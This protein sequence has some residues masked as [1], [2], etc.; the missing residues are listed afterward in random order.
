MSITTSTEINGLKLMEAVGFNRLLAAAILV[1]RP[2][3]REALNTIPSG[4][5]RRAVVASVATI[6][7]ALGE[8][9]FE[10]AVKLYQK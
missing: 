2:D 10:D 7:Q 8:E 4:D 3:W 5:M 6:K 1:G 9:D